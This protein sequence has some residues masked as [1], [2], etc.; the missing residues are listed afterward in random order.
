MRTR[1]PLIITAIFVLG[2]TACIKVPTV[3]EQEELVKRGT[4]PTG[5]P[6][7]MSKRGA[8]RRFPSAG[9]GLI[10]VSFGTSAAVD[11]AHPSVAL[12]EARMEAEISSLRKRVDSLIADTDKQSESPLSRIAAICP[13]LEDVVND[14]VTTIAVENDEIDRKIKKLSLLTRRCP[15]SWD[16]LLWL[17]KEYQRRGR[18]VDA[19]RCFEQVLS[20]DSGNKEAALLL[21]KLREREDSAAVRNL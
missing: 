14:A 8:Y 11:V 21:K 1:Y 15:T 6:A 2:F 13:G 4:F 12:A 9:S 10:P 7:W 17:G 3:K 5:V 20:L 19:T 16:L 18:I